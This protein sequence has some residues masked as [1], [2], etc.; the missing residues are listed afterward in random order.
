MCEALKATVEN[1]VWCE[2]YKPATI[3]DVLISDKIKAKFN[4]YMNQKE[5]PHLMFVGGPGNGKTTCA[6]IIAN[7]ISGY[8]YR[9]QEEY[10][11]A[12]KPLFINASSESGVDVV[13][14]TIVPY[15]TASTMGD[16]LKVVILDEMEESSE[17][18]Q[19]A[20]REVMER[21]ISTTRFILTCNFVNKV[22]EPLKSR[23]PPIVFG[24]MDKVDIMRRI[25]SLL[26]AENVEYDQKNVIKV[27]KDT[28]TDMRRII[29]TLQGLY[30]EDEEGKGKLNQYSTLEESHTKMLDLI[31]NQDLSGF[32]KLMLESNPNYEELTYFLFDSAFKKKIDADNWVPI[33]NEIAEMAKN[34]KLGVNPEITIVNG[35]SQCMQLMG[36]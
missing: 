12:V 34:L 17:K 32:R 20:L 5:I 23:C 2:K 8:A 15:C 25:M 24:E 13:R 6:R 35:V 31:K 28:G 4:V 11:D 19:T 1:S 30:Y 10:E 16:Q 29:N 21:F 26:K 18:F 22:I 33:V 3:D 9:D 14:H 27:I 7:H 36:G